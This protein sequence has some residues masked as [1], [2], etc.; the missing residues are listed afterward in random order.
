MTSMKSDFKF[1]NRG[2]KD[3]AVLIPG[4][5]TDY[6]IFGT[7]ELNYNYVLPVKFSP[8]NLK[9][10]LLEF[11]RETAIERISL[12][13]W[14]LGGFLAAEIAAQYPERIGELILLSIRKDYCPG[15]LKDIRQK[16]KKNKCAYLYKFYRGCFSPEDQD[17]LKWFKNKLL[18]RYAHQI[19]LE[20]LLLGLDYLSN[21]KIEPA[22]LKKLKKIRIFHG[23]DDLVAPFKEARQIKSGLPQAEFICLPKAGHIPFLNPQFKKI[24]YYG[25]T[26][27]D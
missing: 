3:T 14:S 21:V 1:V 10:E 20:S 7:L 4:W 12:F 9:E 18:M 27:A 19:S 2:F 13:G 11:L 5:A 24:F 17:G 6:R 26:N 15:L 16:I 22:S 25:Q 8:F 23:R